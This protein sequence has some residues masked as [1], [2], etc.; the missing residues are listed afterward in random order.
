MAH[1]VNLAGGALNQTFV[2]DNSQ[3][4]QSDT[5]QTCSPYSI[6][7]GFWVTITDVPVGYSITLSTCQTNSTIDTILGFYQS[8]G[9]TNGAPCAEDSCGLQ[10][11]VTT[12]STS[13]TMYAM[14]GCYSRNVRGRIHFRVTA[15]GLPPSP[16]GPPTTGPQPPSCAGRPVIGTIDVQ[17]S[18]H[19][20]L[21]SVDIGNYISPIP[22]A[23]FPHTINNGVWV[24]IVNIPIGWVVNL[25]T[26]GLTA[27]DTIIGFYTVCGASYGG[28]CAEDTCGT[29]SDVET[30]VETTTLY[31]LIGTWL[32]NPVG[33]IGYKLTVTNP[34]NVA[35]TTANVPT[36]SVPT[37]AA[38]TTGSAETN[39]GGHMDGV[40]AAIVVVILL[41]VVGGLAFVIYRMKQR[42]KSG[43]NYS[44]LGLV[45][46]NDYN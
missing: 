3:F 11:S 8:C 2:V 7:N 13:T 17:N 6:Q 12:I 10:S 29:Q 22:I 44:T 42:A 19:N 37:T 40:I 32:S 34:F 21:Y 25:T 43:S 18:P 36:T 33:T 24:T 30:V 20:Q 16:P 38:A 14:I 45:N 15:V 28:P 23:C 35:A 41:G 31:A 1:V 5:P 4:A 27:I 46:D 39:S 9:A 26:C